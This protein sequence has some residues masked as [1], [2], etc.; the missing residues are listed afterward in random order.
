MTGQWT[1]RPLCFG[2]FPEFEKSVFTYMRNAG[3]KIRAPIIGWLLQSAK[4]TILVDTGPLI[5]ELANQWIDLVYHVDQSAAGTATRFCRLD[6][7]G[8]ATMT[9]PPDHPI[10]TV[11]I[12]QIRPSGGEWRPARGSI[13]VIP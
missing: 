12:T 3:E 9:V 7:Q 6:S 5:P 13:Q 2:E 4:E 10:A 1:L 11:A 8:R